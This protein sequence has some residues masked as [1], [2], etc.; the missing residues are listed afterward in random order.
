MIKNDSKVIHVSEEIDNVAFK[1]FTINDLNEI[2]E[3]E[4]FIFN[5]KDKIIDVK[6]MI[7]KKIYDSKFNYL[8]FEN[9]TEKIYKD[10]G[11]LFFDK[12]ILP[13]TIDNYK[14]SEF[15]ISNRIF[16]FI[17]HPRNIEIKKKEIKKIFITKYATENIGKGGFILQDDDFPPL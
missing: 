16:S 3:Q 8:D 13:N 15:T 17:I 11:R 12:G 14:L 6:N 10:F 4:V 1:I 2:I 7:L 5:L 9:I